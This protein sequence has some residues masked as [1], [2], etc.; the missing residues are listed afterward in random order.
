MPKSPMCL[1]SNLVMALLIENP[2]SARMRTAWTSWREEG[3]QII[4]PTLVY[5]EISNALYKYVKAAHL[6]PEEAHDL[7]KQAF[8]L[9]I[10]LYGDAAL[11]LRALELGGNL[12]LP[13]AYDAHY[14]ALAERR[15]A[16]FWTAD[17]RLFEAVSGLLP[18]VRLLEV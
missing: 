14:L 13:A 11:H 7:L 9:E 18:F 4:A 2:Q 6:Q 15:G 1:D 3:H 8:L 12:Q 5:Y 16:E 10:A 17:W